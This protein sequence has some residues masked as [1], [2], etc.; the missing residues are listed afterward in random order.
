[1]K[2]DVS[3]PN[4]I[5]KMQAR[6]STLTA[7]ER[8]VADYISSNPEEVIHRSISELA[9]LTETS[10]A[11]I[12][13]ACRKLGF[14][15]YQE[16]KVLL[17]QDIVS[18]NQ[19]PNGNIDFDTCQSI[20]DII[21]HVFDSTV[22]TLRLTQDIVAPETIEAAADL[23]FD[24]RCVYIFGMGNSG[25]VA[26]DL[27]HKLLR[28]GKMAVSQSD[29]HLQRILVT[30]HANSEDVIVAISHSGSTKDLVENV[31]LGRSRGAKVIS[32]TAYG[33]TP[34]SKIA[35]LSLFTMSDETK[36]NPTS[37]SSRIAQIAIV[38][39]LHTA[40]SFKHKE[41]A[42]RTISDVNVNMSYFKG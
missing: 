40:I 16:F 33:K 24:A 38:D 25:S 19:V 28:L 1:M 18:P 13:R 31:R 27:Q 41:H 29:S 22:Q 30:A 17:A 37:V 21:S 5:A 8:R 2:E 11:T 36:T 7:S 39:V 4:L 10:D 23:L 34:L 20:A 12:I 6:F 35:D 26:Q 42:I 3:A 15:S 9:G 32:I 14:S